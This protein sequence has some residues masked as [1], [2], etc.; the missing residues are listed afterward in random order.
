MANLWPTFT[1][2]RACRCR[3]RDVE[4]L[5]RKCSYSA[6]NGYRYAPSE[7]S[8]VR[9]RRCGAV[10]RTRAKYVDAAPDAED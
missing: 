6:F 9:C 10:W 4:V 2:R 5:Q 3:P 8:T 1:Y 7:Y